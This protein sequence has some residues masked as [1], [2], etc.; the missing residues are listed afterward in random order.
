MIFLIFFLTSCGRC[1]T[2]MNASVWYFLNSTPPCGT[3]SKVIETTQ[4][5]FAFVVLK[6][7]SVY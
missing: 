2:C 7:S 4:E 6:F 5:A 1:F 3:F